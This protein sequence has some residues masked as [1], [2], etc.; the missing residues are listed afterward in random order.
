MSDMA[1]PAKAPKTVDEYIRGFPRNAQRALKE[2]RRAVK[3]AVPMAEEKISYRMPTYMLHGRLLYFAAH[4]NHIGF[5]PM[6]AAISEFAK[7]VARFETSR[8]TIRFPLDK[9]MPLALIKRIVKYRV[10]ENLARAKG[11]RASG[12]APRSISTRSANSRSR[13]RRSR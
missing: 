3:A 12:R 7:D 10:K 2:M 1:M 5:Y 8:G 13:A 11:R 6:A 4:K 9:P